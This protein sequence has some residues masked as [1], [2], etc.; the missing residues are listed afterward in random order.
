MKSVFIFIENIEVFDKRII[1]VFY[2]QPQLFISLAR[3]GGYIASTAL[4]AGK[5]KTFDN[6]YVVYTAVCKVQRGGKS[7]RARADYYYP[8]FVFKHCAP[9]FR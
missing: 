3:F 6:E 5:F 9:P 4:V 2:I 7:R 8:I 1:A